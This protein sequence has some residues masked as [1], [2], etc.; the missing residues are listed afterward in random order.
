MSSVPPV[1]PHP[2]FGLRRR[3]AVCGQ[4]FAN[5]AA[6][7]SHTQ[8]HKL[9][10]FFKMPDIA[11]PAVMPNIEMVGDYTRNADMEGRIPGTDIWKKIFLH[12]YLPANDQYSVDFDATEYDPTGESPEEMQHAHATHHP[13]L[14]GQPQSIFLSSQAVRQ[15]S[16][17]RDGM[18]D[19]GDYH[20]ERRETIM[21][22]VD[23][24]RN[25]QD[26]DKL[27]YH[28]MPA[29]AAMRRQ[30]RSDQLYDVNTIA[31]QQTGD[32]ATDASLRTGG[33]SDTGHTMLFGGWNSGRSMRLDGGVVVQPPSTNVA[34]LSR[35]VPGGKQI[36]DPN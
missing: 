20:K 36:V 30:R 16:D 23:E 7:Y 13:A 10:D 35:L 31:D 8:I 32:W 1:N 9:E 11:D 29:L 24:L 12:D 26:D 22:Q 27:P 5:E 34:G 4:Q 19:G 18:D 28:L 17:Q 14:H 25:T 21:A 15:R 33:I 2:T 3:C 6:W